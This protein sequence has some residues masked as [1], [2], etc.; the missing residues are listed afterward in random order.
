M[1][2]LAAAHDEI[3]GRGIAIGLGDDKTMLSGAG[4]EL[5][6]HPL[7]DDFGRA[8]ARHGRKSEGRS[9][10]YEVRWEKHTTKDT[11]GST[12]GCFG[13]FGGANLPAIAQKKNAS[14]RRHSFFFYL[15]LFSIAHP[16]L[17][18]LRLVSFFI[19][20]VICYLRLFV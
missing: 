8:A 18:Y 12:K 1:Q 17:E 11:K 2:R 3:E 7:A 4:Q 13:K 10:K 20:F 19:P 14:K 5:T 15:I 6:L 9:T 16:E